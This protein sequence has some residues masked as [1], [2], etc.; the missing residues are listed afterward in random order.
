MRNFLLLSLLFYVLIVDAK[1]WHYPG[2][3]QSLQAVIHLAQPYDSLI[4]AAG[5]Y[6]ENLVI[7]KPLTLKAEQSKPGEY[8]ILDGNKHGNVIKVSAKDVHITGLRIEYSGF[9]LTDMNAGIFVD[10]H[11]DNVVIENNFFYYNAF[12]I[13]LDNT[14][15]SVVRNNKIQG[16]LAI[17]S[18]DRGN[19]IH[20]YATT[21]AL[22]EGNEVWHTRDGIYID[23]SNY[24]ELKNN[25]LHDLRYGVHYMYSNHNAVIANLSKNTRSGYAL[26]QSKFLTVLDN[27]SENDSNYGILMNYITDS[28]IVNNR[29][30]GIHLGGNTGAGLGG[31]DA[32]GKAIFIYNSLFNQI[33]NNAF[34]DSGIGIHL[35][36]GSEDNSFSGNQFIANRT[37]VKY[38]ANRRQEWS[39]QGKGNFWSDYLGWDRNKDGIGDQPYEPNDG[40]DKVL[41]KY[42]LAKVLLHSPAIETLHWVQKQFPVFTAQGVRDSYPLMH[43]QH[44]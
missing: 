43:I 34:I 20:L 9:N 31:L 28:K 33:Y 21:K 14:K 18:Q 13:W 15:G 42:P 2:S 24:N 25:F 12:G 4:V 44:D 39:V 16:D 41:W 37:Q 11:A 27:R 32:E 40:I 10:P 5:R 22:I 19:G 3:G 1:E 30:T 29:V 23:T 26:M 35:T 8:A 6:K 36:A 38:V 17:R 7:N